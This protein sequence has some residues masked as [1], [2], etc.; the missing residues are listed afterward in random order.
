MELEVELKRVEM[1]L[2]VACDVM[3][4][5]SVIMV[6]AVATIVVNKR[7]IGTSARGYVTVI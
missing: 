5:I 1:L 7:D 2:L 6:L 3:M 4:V